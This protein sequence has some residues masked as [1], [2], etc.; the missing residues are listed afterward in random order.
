ML[1]VHYVI[2]ND[3][4]EAKGL[5]V[6][7]RTLAGKLA[8]LFGRVDDMAELYA[9]E[10]EW[11]MPASL[12]YPRPMIGRDVIV[13]FHRQV[14]GEFYR[15]DC[16]VEILDE[17]GDAAG[18]A[19]RFAYRAFSLLKNDWYANQYTLFVRSGPDGIREVFEDFDTVTTYNFFRA[20]K[21]A[22]RG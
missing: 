17:C 10:I 21:I 19:A 13:A 6:A 9:S 8:E 22:F 16:E 18:S 12:P 11:S 2:G 7:A 20:E 1:D 5:D 14:W 4:F 3:R 15:P